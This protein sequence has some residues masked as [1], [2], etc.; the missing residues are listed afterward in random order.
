MSETGLIYRFAVLL[1]HG[2]QQRQAR[3]HEVKKSMLGYCRFQHF[4]EVKML[5]TFPFLGI[6]F[7]AIFFVKS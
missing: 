3:V 7:L 5:Y 4:T 1:I 6:I 2:A